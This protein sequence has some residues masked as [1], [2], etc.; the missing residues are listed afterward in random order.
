MVKT[1]FGENNFFLFT[2][3]VL[4]FKIFSGGFSKRMLLVYLACALFMVSFLSAIK[5][6]LPFADGSFVYTF[7]AVLIGLPILFTIYFFLVYIFLKAFE[8]K[9]PNFLES[10]MVFSAIAAPFLVLGHLLNFLSSLFL[11]SW[12]I[13][14]AGITIIVLGFY[15]IFNLIFVFSN[16][17]GTSKMRVFVSFALADMMIGMLFVLYYLTYLIRSINGLV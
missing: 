9:G 13:Y 1:K 6:L 10:L 5:E 8:V 17:F 15:L 16:Y 2:K 3:S 12:L 4:D 11:W 7:F 14:F